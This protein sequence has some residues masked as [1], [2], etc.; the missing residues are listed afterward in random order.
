MTLLFPSAPRQTPG[1][2]TKSSPKKRRDV[3]GTYRF[4]SI[5]GGLP[6]TPGP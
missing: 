3:G 4:G 6:A 2:Q 1:M 5:F